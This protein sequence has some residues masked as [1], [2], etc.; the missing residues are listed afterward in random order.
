MGGEKFIIDT[1]IMVCMDLEE[2]KEWL[3]NNANNEEYAAYEVVDTILWWHTLNQGGINP[4]KVRLYPRYIFTIDGEKYEFD[5]LIVL[6]QQKTEKKISVEFKETDV[7]KVV[8]QAAARRA[9]VDYS[10]IATTPTWMTIESLFIMAYL[11]I[12]W[13]V[14]GKD[15]CGKFAHMVLPS[16]YKYT[17]RE[18]PFPL[19][20]FVDL[21]LDDVII[22]EIEKLKSENTKKDRVKSLFDYLGGENGN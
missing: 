22:A 11:G 6:E 9:F 5:L 20:F 21:R 15:D 13:I 18:L 10:Y 3:K 7:R 16:Y 14:W 8:K 17:S 19:N 12:G 4:K 1:H 2:Y